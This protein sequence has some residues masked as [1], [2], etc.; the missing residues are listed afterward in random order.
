MEGACPDFATVRTEHFFKPFLELI[1]RLVCEGDC[2][3]FPRTGYIDLHQI[4]DECIGKIVTVEV[5]LN[6]INI[7]L[8]NGTADII[9][10][11]CLAELHNVCNAVDKNCCFA[12]ACTRKH[13]QGTLRAEDCLALHIVHPTELFF[14]SLFS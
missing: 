12:T 10:I 1:C 14:Y 2:K 4:F 7:P 3:D 11:I 6:C 13:K 5:C 8:L 9:G